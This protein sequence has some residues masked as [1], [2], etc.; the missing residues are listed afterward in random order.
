MKP[1]LTTDIITRVLFLRFKSEIFTGYVTDYDT[2]SYLVTVRHPYKGIN[3]NDMIDFEYY[4]EDQWK[5]SKQ[6]IHFHE[7]PEVDIAVISFRERLFTQF[8]C[9]EISAANI[10]LG[11]DGYFLGFPLRLL[12]EGSYINSGRPLPLIKKA[13]LSGHMIYKSANIFLLDGN[14]SKG[15]SGSPAFFYNYSTKKLQFSGVIAGYF[16]QE[17]IKEDHLGEWPYEENS[18]IIIMYGTE[19]ILSIFQNLILNSVR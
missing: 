4:H 9:P 8:S 1:I 15:F 7:N 14:C 5:Q 19:Y 11:D 10:L 18:G 2:D 16:P 3:N 6:L 17:N 12:I 13:V